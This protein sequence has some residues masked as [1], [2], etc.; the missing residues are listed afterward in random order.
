VVT[1]HDFIHE[2]FPALLG[3][4][5]GFR[6]Q[7]RNVI[8]NAD[9][10]VAVSHS[11]KEDIL[12]YTRAEESKIVV[13]HHGVKD[14]FL[15]P[16]VSEA[17]IQM[18]REAHRIAGPY[19]LYVGRRGHYKNF[20]TLLRAFVRVAPQTDGYLVAV[21][22]EKKLEPWQED[23]LIRSCLEHRVRLLHVV[24]DCSLVTAYAGASAFVFP[25]L[26]EGFG[27][28]L[29]ESMAVGTPIIAS[30][31]SVFREVAG[32]SPLYFDPYDEKAL[33]DAMKTVLNDTVAQTFAE[34]GYKRVREFSWNTAAGKL[35]DVYLAL[36]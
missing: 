8:E 24:S 22:G 36:A 7:K 12:T 9:V 17:D 28:P 26:D 3:D 16:S 21:G 2:K 20:G 4:A 10:I 1:V 25:S 14:V 13:I 11:T 32:E 5:E 34:K 30:N 33:A 27:I 29:L 15:A 19:W 18:F 35:R 23:F 6:E 31:I